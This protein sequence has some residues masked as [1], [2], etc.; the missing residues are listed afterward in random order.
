MMPYTTPKPTHGRPRP[1]QRPSIARTLFPRATR[2]QALMHAP[3][4]AYP[5]YPQCHPQAHF[6]QHAT[7]GGD[8]VHGALCPR[9]LREPRQL[10][11]RLHACLPSLDIHPPRAVLSKRAIRPFAETP[12]LPI[13]LWFPARFHVRQCALALERYRYGARK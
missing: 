9:S 2:T 10:I 3:W 12:Y 11:S 1:Q 4:K 6:S 5:T 7:A 8:T 13:S